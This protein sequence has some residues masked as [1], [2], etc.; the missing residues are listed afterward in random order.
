MIIIWQTYICIIFCACLFLAGLYDVLFLYL[1]K[2]RD[3]SNSLFSLFTGGQAALQ[4]I[5]NIVMMYL[6]KSMANLTEPMINMISAAGKSTLYILLLSGLK[7]SSHKTGTI[8]L[9]E[10]FFS[11]F[12][13]LPSSSSFDY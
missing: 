12:F 2:S 7:L 4:C 3:F 6:L 10:I 1:T 5:G 8:K 9:E 11:Y 13:L